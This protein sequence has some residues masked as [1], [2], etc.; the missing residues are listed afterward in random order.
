MLVGLILLMRVSKSF[1][2]LKITSLFVLVMFSFFKQLVFFAALVGSQ[3]EFGGR[4][5]I[6]IEK[7][8]SILNGTPKRALSI[9]RTSIR[10]KT[11]TV[12]QKEL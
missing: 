6:K 11:L 9:S 12:I 4:R 10:L 5:I 8:I 3:L 2:A 7:T 1:S